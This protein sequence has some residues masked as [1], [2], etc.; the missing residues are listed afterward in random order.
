MK[1]I[2]DYQFLIELFGILAFVAYGL[3]KGTELVVKRSQALA[4]HSKNGERSF[5][6]IQAIVENPDE[7]IAQLHKLR[8]EQIKQGANEQTLKP[9]DERI[10]QVE[11]VK[12]N[13]VWLEPF[14]P[15]A[16]ELLGAGF[17]A[18][19]HVLEAF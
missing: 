19:K 1:K 15:Y 16:D 2:M 6:G 11:W 12:K 3:K 17:K 8:A 4:K 14:A 5:T 13:Q 9:L 10:S 7:I 18:F